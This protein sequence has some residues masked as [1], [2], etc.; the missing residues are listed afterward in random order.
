[1]MYW[2]ATLEMWEWEGKQ[3]IYTARVHVKLVNIET[4]V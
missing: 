1:M 3:D 4:H 2:E